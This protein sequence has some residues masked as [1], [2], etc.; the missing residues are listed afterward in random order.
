MKRFVLALPV[1][2]LAL[3]V[4][5]AAL[6]AG[7]LTPLG[8]SQQPIA[9]RDHHVD[10]VLQNGFA[11]TEVTQTFFNP[12]DVALEALYAFPVPRSASLS[13]MTLFAGER[14]LE[15]E[16]V[17]KEEAQRI[18]EEERDKGNDAGH[19]SKEGY[20]RFE[21][22]VS[23]VP[24]QAETR[25]RFVYYQPLEIDTGVG[26]YVYPL[27]E[28][29][30]DELAKSFWLR[31]EKVEGTFSAN[32]ELKSAWPVTEVRV[33][34]FEAAATVQ[35]L[36]EGHTRV[37]IQQQGVSLSRD[38]VLYYR[39]EDGL[40]GR[41]EVIAHRAD[42]AQPGTFM[43]VLTP[44][45]D[46]GRLAGGADYVFVL[47]VSGSMSGGKLATLARGVA[48]G[49]GELDPNDRFRVVAFSS[50]ARELTRGFR[51]ATPDEVASTIREVEAI[52]AGGSTNLYDG[53]DLALR[54]LDDDRA[55]SLVL[56]TDAVTNTGVVE[57]RRFHE[58]LRQYDVRVFGFLLG[59]S[60]NWP[61]MRAICDATGGFYAGISNADDVLGQI[62]LAK[63]KITHEALHDAELS[64][65]GV[66][67]SDATG[68]LV[69]KVY[70]GQQLVLFGRYAEGG[71]GTLTLKARLTGQ[72][73]TYQT[74]F[75]FP[76]RE[77]DNPEIERLWALSL[78]EELED[79]ANAGLLDAEEMEAAVRDLGVGYQLVTDETS[80][81][82]LDDRAF[83]SHGIERR[84]RE[85]VARERSAQTRR[86]GQPIRSYR[87]DR[88]RPAFDRP[89][90]SLG[91]GSGAI[92]PVLGLIGLALAGA[93]A[94]T[95]RRW[96]AR[97]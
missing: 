23:P 73:E 1:W 38:L 94:S 96:R 26:R 33:P 17:P 10:V 21:F 18:Y 5:P 12:N 41:V 45:I 9:I 57:P 36:G 54:G 95:R 90:P 48:R 64:V 31:N 7:T 8:S 86:A 55:T 69:G 76:D 11:R 16:V 70:R 37:E 14:Q 58:L 63:S 56:V 3:A 83:E 29:G 24:P 93:A 84:N 85:R 71:R 75:E 42:P 34:G 65:R 66:K 15:G 87:V 47:D 92:D 30:T 50:R 28:G 67:V 22:R 32:L 44:G 82:V 88:E 60:G 6:A 80:M 43:A 51:P 27:E 49:L 46:L 39:L 62:L 72:D 97:A 25:V 20:Q 40:P 52:T 77:E 35:K 61:L 13:E 89:A 91:G 4:A 68:A 2:A 74:T 78:I 81:V 79:R 59:N 19:A 53:V